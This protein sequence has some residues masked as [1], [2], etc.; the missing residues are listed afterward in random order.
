MK[1][2]LRD[3]VCRRED[4]F[5]ER[6]RMRYGRVCSR[7]TKAGYPELYAVEWEDTGDVEEGFMPHGLS[8]AVDRSAARP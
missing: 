4:V 3:R 5:D 6:S 2:A 1:F 7:Y 8:P